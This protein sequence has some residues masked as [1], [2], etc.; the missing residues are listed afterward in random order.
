MTALGVAYQVTALI[1]GNRNK[2]AKR[3]GNAS[4]LI[5]ALPESFAG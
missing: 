4:I 5:D 1:T 3:Y 2:P